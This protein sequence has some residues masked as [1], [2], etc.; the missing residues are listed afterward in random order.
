MKRL[1]FGVGGGTADFCQY[2]E[3][4]EPNPPSS[5]CDPSLKL[6]ASIVKSNIDGLSNIRDVVKVSKV[7][8]K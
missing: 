6:C 7:N 8:R 5:A 4:F 2:I 1:Y 3:S